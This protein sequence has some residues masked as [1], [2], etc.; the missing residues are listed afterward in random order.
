MRAKR[1]SLLA[2]LTVCICAVMLPVSA[3]AESTTDTKPPTFTVKVDGDALRIEAED[4][5]SG[6]EA[7]YIAGRRVGAIV[8]GKGYVPLKDY[9][10]TD[11]QISVYAVD[12][13]GNKSDTQLLDNPY[14]VAPTPTPRPT[15][16]PSATAA[17]QPE[18]T[19]APAQPSSSAPAPSTV[20]DDS[21]AS[22]G[23]PFTPDGTGNVLDEATENEDDKQFYTITSEAGNVFYMI[24]DGERDADN[25]YFL[26]TVT[27]NDLMALAET[28]EGSES[29]VPVPETCAC[30]ERCVAGAVNTAC[31]VCKIDMNACTGKEKTPEPEPEEPQPEPEDDGNAGLIIFAVAALVAVGGTAYYIKIVRP[32][33]QASLDDVDGDFEDEGY[34]EDFDPDVE[35]GRYGQEDYL[36][37]E[38]SEYANGPEDGE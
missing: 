15:A 37:E 2:A 25:V 5:I 19:P 6:V 17:P 35:Y 26:N 32:R 29:A 18:A 23:N 3:Y 24:I 12:Y 34:G 36:P 10:G 9:A 13:A 31:P 7:V 11:K 1:L 8:D 14:Y 27:E 16:K 38:E 20:S 4:D 28:E 21:T 30:P 22:G 33:R